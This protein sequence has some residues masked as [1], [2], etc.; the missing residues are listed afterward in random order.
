MKYIGKNKIFNKPY[1]RIAPQRVHE[2]IRS[3]CNTSG[4]TC[5]LRFASGRA[6]SRT[7]H[8]WRCSLLVLRFLD[9]RI[10]WP[11]RSRSWK[12]NI[13]TMIIVTVTNGDLPFRQCD[14]IIDNS[15]WRRIFIFSTSFMENSCVQS[16]GDDNKGQFRLFSRGESWVKTRQLFFDY[17]HLVCSYVFNLT[18]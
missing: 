16:L 15:S 11:G 4:C 12:K 10:D 8:K 9:E 18:V 17:F 3:S 7:C 6:T 5:T 13:L 1:E 14:A 2:R